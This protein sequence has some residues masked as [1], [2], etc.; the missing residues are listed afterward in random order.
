MEERD[1]SCVRV[2][3]RI[4]RYKVKDDGVILIY[5]YDIYRY[6]GI[7]PSDWEYIEIDRFPLDCYMSLI[8]DL[9]GAIKK[10]ESEFFDKTLYNIENITLD[11]NSAYLIKDERNEFWIS[12]RGDRA[13]FFNGVYVAGDYLLYGD[14]AYM[15]FKHIRNRSFNTDLLS[16][17]DIRKIETIIE[18]DRKKAERA[19]KLKPAIE[20]LKESN[21][22]TDIILS[23]ES[24]YRQVLEAVNKE[25]TLDIELL[26]FDM[27]EYVGNQHK[28]LKYIRPILTVH[29]IA[30]KFG[31]NLHVRVVYSVLESV[32]IIDDQDNTRITE[33]GLEYGKDIDDTLY[34]YPSIMSFFTDKTI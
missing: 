27:M 28:E 16:N 20:E 1:Y 5:T 33:F 34:F 24:L 11:N 32:G 21:R 14:V 23:L 25:N 13:N 10:Q 17:L 31:P 4:Y 22:Q 30:S 29:D 12:N 26:V 6:L 3:K 8:S 18:L 2:E 19:K 7:R 9:K 15:K